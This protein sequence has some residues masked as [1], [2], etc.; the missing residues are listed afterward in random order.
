MQTANR[1]QKIAVTGATGR[2]G[3]HLVE[4]LEQRGHDVVPIARSIGSRRGQRRGSRRGARRGR[5]HHRYGD[6]ALARPGGG[7]GLLH[8]FGAETCSEPAPKP[9]RSGSSLSRSSA[10]TS[11]RAATTRRRWRRSRRC[12]KARC[13]SES[14]ARPSS[15]SSSIRWSGGRSKT[16]W[17]TCP[18]C[19]RSSLPPAS[20]PTRSPTRPRSRRSRT[21][22]ITEVAGPQEERLADVAAALFAS[23]GDSL[24]IRET[25]GGPLAEPG[26]PDAAAYAEGAALPNPGA[27]LAC[28]SF[29]EWLA[30]A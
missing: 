10:S 25:R 7:D 16:A 26:D 30:K 8:R 4:I 1:S 17:P 27:K 28:P 19:E 18:R 2:V 20:S 15:T 11:S 3:S 22:A 14:F 12:S 23:R 6:G 13:R 29:E 9:G 21:A 24:E 5:D